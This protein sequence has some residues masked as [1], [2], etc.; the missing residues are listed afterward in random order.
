MVIFFLTVFVFIKFQGFSHFLDTWL[1]SSEE[2][3]YFLIMILMLQ[4]M[5]LAK[6]TKAQL[7]KL[8]LNY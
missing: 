8:S 3:H 7:L 2:F 6:T 5:K 1:R 4:K